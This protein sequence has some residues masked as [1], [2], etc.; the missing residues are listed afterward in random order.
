MNGPSSAVVK[1]AVLMG[2]FGLIMS[3]RQVLEWVA[4]MTSFN[5]LLLWYVIFGAFI[6]VLGY[7][8]FQAKWDIRYTIA[9][10]LISW[11]F[12]IVLYFPVSS[13]STDITGAQ[14]TGVESATED[15]A[16]MDFL[17]TL[18]VHDSTGILTYAVVPA[19]MILLAGWVIAPS[20]FNR[21][22]ASTVGRGH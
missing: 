7:W 19:L 21:I 13:Y 3:R 12:G 16:T 2:G 5:A 10:V 8:V 22:I 4:P 18:G 20:F 17:S 15:A 9:L 1:V 11:A 6:T 14:L